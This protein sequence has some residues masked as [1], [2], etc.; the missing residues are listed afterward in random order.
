VFELE[1]G[2]IQIQ[3]QAVKIQNQTTVLGSIQPKLSVRCTYLTIQAVQ[4]IV[5]NSH[6]LTIFSEVQQVL[7]GSY[8]LSDRHYSVIALKTLF[9]NAR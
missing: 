3:Y 5:Q 8:N 1:W 9:F 7:E 4:K 2:E 6:L